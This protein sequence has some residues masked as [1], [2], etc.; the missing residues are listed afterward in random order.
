MPVC[1]WPRKVRNKRSKA[2]C[3]PTGLCKCVSHCYKLADVSEGQG[4]IS[5]LEPAFGIKHTISVQDTSFLSQD[6]PQKIRRKLWDENFR[7]FHYPLVGSLAWECTSDLLEMFKPHLY[8]QKSRN[9]K[10]KS[11]NGQHQSHPMIPEDPHDLKNLVT[12]KE[13]SGNIY[14]EFRLSTIILPF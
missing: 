13:K 14:L 7:A 6:C 2:V 11:Q 10:V 5:F 9:T 1:A 8:A 3:H 12:S 4:L